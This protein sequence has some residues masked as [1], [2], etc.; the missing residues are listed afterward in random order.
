MEP[1]EGD[2]ELVDKQEACPAEQGDQAAAPAHEAPHDAPAGP[3][4]KPQVLPT[5]GGV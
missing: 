4:S 5:L 2:W 3:Q 1:L